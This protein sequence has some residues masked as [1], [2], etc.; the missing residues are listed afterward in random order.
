MVRARLP[1]I[2]LPPNPYLCVFT[3]ISIL[4][5]ETLFIGLCRSVE[6]LLISVVLTLSSAFTDSPRVF[7]STNPWKI[8]ATFSTVSSTREEYV[9]L[10]EDLKASAPPELKKGEKR[11]KLDQGHLA[12]IKALEN[13]IEVIDTELTVSFSWD[14]GR[15]VT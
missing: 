9:A 10:I 3:G 8:T 14:Q 7:V 2:V 11:S 13:R 15:V 6:L 4:V 1:H 12:L 5:S